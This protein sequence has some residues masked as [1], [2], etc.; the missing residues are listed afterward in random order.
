MIDKIFVT[1]MRSISSSAIAQSWVPP[2][3]GPPRDSSLNAPDD[4]PRLIEL[5]EKIEPLVEL[6]LPIGA[7]LAVGMLVYGGYLWMSSGGEPD[8]IQKAQGTLTWSALGL[9]FLFLIR[10]LLNFLVGMVTS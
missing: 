6:I 4:P 7:L 2:I 3:Y 9:V 8:K 5:V 10:M 1:I